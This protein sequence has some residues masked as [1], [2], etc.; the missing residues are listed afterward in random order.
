MTSNQ[1]DSRLKKQYAKDRRAIEAH[2]ADIRKSAARSPLRAIQY[3]IL[4]PQ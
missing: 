3:C 1:I 2:L 4:T